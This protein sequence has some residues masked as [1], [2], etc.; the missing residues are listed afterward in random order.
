MNSSRDRKPIYSLL[1]ICSGFFAAS[2]TACLNVAHNEF[3]LS[4][5]LFV[6][7]FPLV[8]ISYSLLKRS[9]V[10]LKTSNAR[11]TVTRCLCGIGAVVLYIEAAQNISIINAQTLYYTAPLFTGIF[12][13]LYAIHQ[14]RQ[15]WLKV[16]PLIIFGFL[17]VV[18]VNRPSFNGVGFGYSFAALLSAL[19]LS[20]ASLS[21]KGLGRRRE[22]SERTIFYF[23]LTC[24]ITA[25][26]LFPLE[27]KPFKSFLDPIFILLALFTVLQ[28]F[29]VTLGWGRG[30][31]L[32][33]CVFQFSGVPFAVMFGVLFFNESLSLSATLGILILLAS[34]LA[35]VMIMN[36]STPAKS[37]GV[38]KAETAILSSEKP[39]K[40][41]EQ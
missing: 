27:S 1:V 10:S 19:F 34:E 24:C 7:Y 15:V 41:H 2:I 38:V 32:L 22:P 9:H 26:A 12:F 11:L 17:G 33:N 21:L 37:E 29:C 20:M 31:T 30:S 36:M 14:K 6:R 40:T 16:V 25:A 13:C 5:I 28:Q 8:L 18:L 3:C 4:Q 35:A 39:R 23:S